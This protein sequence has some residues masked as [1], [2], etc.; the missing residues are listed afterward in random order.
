MKRIIISL[1]LALPAIVYG[2]F[3]YTISSDVVWPK[4]SVDQPKIKERIE[5]TFSESEFSEASNS[6]VPLSVLVRR[7]GTVEEVILGRGQFDLKVADELRN[8]LKKWKFHPSDREQV[9]VYNF[10]VRMNP[11]EPTSR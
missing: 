11:E 8:S 2:G 10:D 3:S 1:L 7:N 5:P 6:K 9:I 4:Q